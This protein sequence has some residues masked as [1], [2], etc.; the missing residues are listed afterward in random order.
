M[1]G[2]TY[3]TISVDLKYSFS[4]FSRCPA[5]PGLD[6]QPTQGL[7]ISLQPPNKKPRLSGLGQDVN[8]NIVEDATEIMEELEVD[9]VE[10]YKLIRT[11]AEKFLQ[12]VPS[13]RSRVS[14]KPAGDCSPVTEDAQGE[15]QGEKVSSEILNNNRTSSSVQL[16]NRAP[17]V[18]LS[19][20]EK[21]VMNL[22]QISTSAS[23][24]EE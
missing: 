11:L 2:K 9:E 18:G 15:T 17:R 7:A 22:H 24:K 21:K 19:K 5:S 4:W 12:A 3:L 23:V 1:A 8:A 13:V 20:L 14:L 10:R 16:L 6:L